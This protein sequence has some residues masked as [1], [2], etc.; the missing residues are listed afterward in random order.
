VRLLF[1]GDLDRTGF[2]TVTQ[3]LGSAL[4]ALGEDVRF[5]SS[6]AFPDLPEPFAS[7][8]FNMESLNVTQSRVGG[9]TPELIEAATFIPKVLIGEA[10]DYFAVSGHAWGPWR[11]DAAVL[12][13][14]FAHVRLMT[15]PYMDAFKMVPTWHYVPIEG[16]D[17]PPKWGETWQTIRPVAVTNF[18]A[19]EIANVMGYT[20]PVI[21]H[22]VSE[23]FWPV[24]PAKP[25]VVKDDQD[26]E[27]T[28]TTKDQA[29]AFFHWNPRARIIL[30]TDRHMPRKNYNSMLRAVAPVLV[31]RD[32]TFLILHC[33]I[34][35]Q[36][37]YIADTTSK[38]V[39]K[40]QERILVN[41]GGGSWD[42][43]TLAVL[44][45]AA[46]VYVSTC[47]E[48]FG[49]T[50]AEAIASG[51]PAVGMDYSSIPEVIGPAGIVCPVDTLTDNEYDHFWARPVEPEVT[52]AVRWLLEHP[53]RAQS[54]GALGPRHVRAHF[55]WQESAQRFATLLGGGTLEPYADS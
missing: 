55:T 54:I 16:V 6:N 5:I 14:D 53:S 36:G 48:G 15:S 12:L 21:Y 37:G 24:S 3:D 32:D 27:R 8:T 23:D 28:I 31:E 22:G 25:M 11:P 45:N 42:R 34:L 17:L 1:F 51:V 26:V 41:D 39:Q 44:Y 19:A 7:R 13:G 9:P 33:R 38:L 30:R 49:F 46:D 4:L 40:A 52:K 20:P 50:V 35:D 29:K 47:A 2:G 10:Q 18:G 43:A